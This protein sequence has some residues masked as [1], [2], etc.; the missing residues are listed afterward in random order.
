[1]M[2]NESDFQ[3]QL[4]ENVDNANRIIESYLPKE[5]GE[6]K[7]IAA[8]VNYSI[9]AGG[10][11]LRPILMW[12]T[13]RM[14]MD[15]CMDA[16]PFMA[17]MEMM[18]TSSLIHDDL[19]AIDNDDYRRGKRTTHVVYGEDMA[20]LAGDVLM[21]CAYETAVHGILKAQD[22]VRYGKALDIFARKSG[23]NGMLGGQ[24]VDVYWTGKEFTEDRLQ[25]I[26]AN[27]TGAL[28]EASMMIGAVLA[29]A[30][31]EDVRQ[32]EKAGHAIGMAFQIQDDILDICGDEKDLGKPIHSDE[33]N[34]KQ[35]YVTMFGLDRARQDV[36]AYTN[37][38]ET[39]LKET[40]K[41]NAFLL[42]LIHSLIHRKF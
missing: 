34:D 23:I 2:K 27:K 31:D 26:H 13:S 4:N 9:H 6:V 37:T 30:S 20:I 12:E 25:F 39:I 1:M 32:I 10:K 29:G 36:D 28:I 16:E 15:H 11:R 19:P 38:A 35:S 3:K 8:P 33:K 22:P 21:N 40:G 24:S 14:Y 41:T 5:E 18:H 7:I 17:A 42:Q